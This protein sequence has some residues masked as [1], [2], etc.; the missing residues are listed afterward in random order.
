MRD[1]SKSSVVLAKYTTYK[2]G[3]TAKLYFKPKNVSELVAFIKQLPKEEKLF[4]LGLGSNVLIR[5]GGIDAAVI[6]IHN[7]LNTIEIIE[8]NNKGIL[9]KVG[10]GLS[11]AKLAKF[12]VN[13][14]LADGVWFSGIPGTLG[15]ALCMNAGAFGGETWNHVISVE[16]INRDGEI[17]HRS[18]NDYLVSYRAA[19]LKNNLLINNTSEEWFIS[20]VLFFSFSD[21][22]SKDLQ[23]EVKLLLQKRKKTQPIGTLNCGSVF[24]NPVNDFAARLIDLSRLKG[25]R[26]GG[27]MVS[28]KHANFIINLGNATAADLE[29][30]IYFVQERVFMEHNV[31]L[32]LEVKII[33]KS[34]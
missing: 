13:N 5:D 30:L 17:I 2:V 18:K 20:G 12:C 21:T 29:K 6:H 25:E 3:G 34:D 19:R 24:K 33:G 7:V 27:A 9:I 14:S 22:T 16:V 31:L 23:E 15:G 8:K 4:W 32:D 10:A 11:C 26:V 1:I 28:E